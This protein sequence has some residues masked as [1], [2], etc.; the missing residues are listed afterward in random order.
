MDLVPGFKNWVKLDTAAYA[1]IQLAA[2]RERCEKIKVT[3]AQRDCSICMHVGDLASVVPHV[4]DTS[5]TVLL[6]AEA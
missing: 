4:G 5:R 2:D 6:E 1:S 3:V